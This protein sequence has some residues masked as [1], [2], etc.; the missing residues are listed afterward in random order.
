MVYKFLADNIAT[1]TSLLIALTGLVG[2]VFGAK[3]WIKS[4]QSSDRSSA[5]TENVELRK[6][7]RAEN[8]ELK[9]DNKELRSA[10]ERLEHELAT[11]NTELVRVR[12]L[13]N[14]DSARSK[15]TNNP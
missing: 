9:S 4:Q 11:V 12:K 1:L 3:K 8:M 6:E 14:G 7:M 5:W 10:I 13:Q 2:S 15:A